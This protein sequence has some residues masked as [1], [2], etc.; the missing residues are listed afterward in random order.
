MHTQK[1]HLKIISALSLV[2]LLALS[3]PAQAN[4]TIR[5][6][7]NQYDQTITYNIPVQPGKT[8][9]NH[10]GSVTLP[11]NNHIDN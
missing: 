7:N 5:N 6:L 1:T 8:A 2:G 10:H 9:K 4:Y 3:A 11:K